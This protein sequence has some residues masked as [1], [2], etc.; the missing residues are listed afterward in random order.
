MQKILTPSICGSHND[1]LQ[2]AQWNESM[3]A[4]NSW[5]RSAEVCLYILSYVVF[6][7]SHRTD[8]VFEITSNTSLQRHAMINIFTKSPDESIKELNIDPLRFTKKTL[9]GP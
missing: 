6:E 9:H 5:I 2:L 3:A 4:M 8:R 7:E 1:G